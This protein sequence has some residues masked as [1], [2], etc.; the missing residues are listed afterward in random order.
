MTETKR[1]AM[2]RVALKFEDCEITICGGVIYGCFAAA[3]IAGHRYRDY[4]R[5]EPAD[6][7]AIP[8]NLEGVFVPVVD[9]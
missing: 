6:G 8:N 4:L 2:G 3:D 7:T 9:L 1:P 5:L